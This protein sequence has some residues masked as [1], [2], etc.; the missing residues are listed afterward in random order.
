MLRIL[1]AALAVVLVACGSGDD[2]STDPGAEPTTADATPASSDGADAAG[3][4]ITATIAG[5]WQLVEGTVDDATITPVDGHAVTLTIDRGEVAGSTGCNDFS[6]AITGEL[7]DVA[8]E[9]VAVTE[10][11]CMDDGVMDVEAAWLDAI[12]RVDR[13]EADPDGLTLGGP[14][15]E[16]RLAPVG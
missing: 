6:G 9:Q 7:P 8:F 2:P 3:G 10:M 12:A 5:D 4:G 16:L 15:V 13:A 14:G 11:A 1:L